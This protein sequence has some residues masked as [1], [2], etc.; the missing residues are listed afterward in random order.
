MEP[1]GEK[2]QMSSEHFG[3]DGRVE[4]WTDGGPVTHPSPRGIFIA[5]VSVLPPAVDRRRARLPLAVVRDTPPGG[6]GCGR[7]EGTLRALHSRCRGEV[8]VCVAALMCSSRCL[9]LPFRQFNLFPA[10]KIPRLCLLVYGLY[11]PRRKP[12]SEGAQRM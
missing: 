4:Q 5:P 9:F 8:I 11:G 10:V 1:S 2:W 3:P 12:G 6:R 7:R